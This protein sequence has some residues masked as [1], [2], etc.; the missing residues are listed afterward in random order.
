MEWHLLSSAY[1]PPG[2]TAL[3]FDPLAP[4]LVSASATGTL[5]S[6][7]C[8]P[9]QPLAGRYSSWRA[10]FG[11]VGELDIDANGVLSVGGGSGGP[12][13]ALSRQLVES[14]IKL[15]NRRGVALW[16]AQCVTCSL[17]LLLPRR[18]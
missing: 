15:A 2:A 13:G 16:S 6:H 4:L 8:T 18:R 3:A 12:A 7:V 11:P 9:S 1:I 5:T 17:T 10:H 14:N